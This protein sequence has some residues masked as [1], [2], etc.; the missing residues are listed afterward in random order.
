MQASQSKGRDRGGTTLAQPLH[1]AIKRRDGLK[2][3]RKHGGTNMFA[4]RFGP[5]GTNQGR[6][7]SA[8]TCNPGSDRC[9]V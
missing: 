6:S 3:V 4:S 7:R 8:R 1:H 9:L 2:K 5:T